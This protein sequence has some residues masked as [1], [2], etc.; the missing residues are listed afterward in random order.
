MF[1]L[2]SAM[3]SGSMPSAG[4]QI[5]G[6]GA[7]E[8]DVCPRGVEMGVV[9]HVL[10]RPADDRRGSSRGP[11]LVGGDDF[12]EA[13]QFADLVEEAIEAPAP[14]YDSSPRM[15]P[16]HWS[17][18]IAAVPLSVNRSISTSSAGTMKQVVSAPL[19]DFFSLLEGGELDRLDRLD[20]ERLDNGF[21]GVLQ[22]ENGRGGRERGFQSASKRNK[23]RFT[24][25]SSRRH[26]QLIAMCNPPPTRWAMGRQVYLFVNSALPN[27]P[28]PRIVPGLLV[29][30]QIGIETG[31]NSGTVAAEMV[32]N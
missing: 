15:M 7:G 20:F 5:D 3:R 13:G 22:R 17:A 18:L 4:G 8:L 29:F 21:H 10:A 25:S 6:H 31:P 14:A 11:S 1:P 19:K 2:K 16:A 9:G 12:L 23:I 28:F 27:L 26:K 32:V 24:A 30:T